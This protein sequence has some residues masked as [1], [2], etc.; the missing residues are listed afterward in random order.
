MDT[1]QSQ[2]A[3]VLGEVTNQSSSNVSS[4]S[5]LLSQNA[6][7]AQLTK[8]IAGQQQQSE[9][10]MMK[11]TKSQESSSAPS[12]VHHTLSRPKPNAPR[13]SSVRIC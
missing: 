11:S 7:Q 8:A 9:N 1:T 4:S 3:S 5:S 2:S 13:R 6:F 12:L 10:D